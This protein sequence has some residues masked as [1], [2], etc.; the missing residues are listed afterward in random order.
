MSASMADIEVVDCLVVD[1]VQNC[2]LHAL[3]RGRFPC[4]YVIQFKPNN[5]C[6][7]FGYQSNETFSKHPSL[8]LDSIY[9]TTCSPIS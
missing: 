8:F 3:L 9:N 5:Q 7:M 1:L 6:I 2:I 4:I